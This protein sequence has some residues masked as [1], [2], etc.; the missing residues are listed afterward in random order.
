MV[1][2]ISFEDN[3]VRVLLWTY[4]K[5]RFLPLWD[6]IEHHLLQLSFEVVS[7]D[8]HPS[9]GF[10]RQR[11]YQV[12]NFDLWRSNSFYSYSFY[13][14]FNTQSSRKRPIINIF[15]LILRFLICLIQGQQVLFCQREES[16]CSRF[17]CWCIDG[18]KVR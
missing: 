13:F 10:R 3:I 8:L 2:I 16:F 18:G 6:L 12:N 15:H 4:L 17:H 1:S 5:L 7:L 9:I 11:S 14:F